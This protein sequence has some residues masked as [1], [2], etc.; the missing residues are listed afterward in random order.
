[1]KTKQTNEQ[2]SE[3]PKK[4][5]TPKKIIFNYL[6]NVIDELERNE[7][8]VNYKT[9]EEK[10]ELSSS[11]IKNYFNSFPDLKTRI[12]SE[13]QKKYDLILNAIDELERDLENVTMK[14]I[15]EKTLISFYCIQ[16]YIYKNPELKVRLTKFP[17]SEQVNIR[18][19]PNQLEKLKSLSIEKETPVSTLLRNILNNYFE[20]NNI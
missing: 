19:E 5:N 4:R 10:S 6:S 7:I 8:E 1:M 18:F 14:K 11:I 12:K 9:I 20:T 15:E 13:K 17:K 3:L 2:V 16:N